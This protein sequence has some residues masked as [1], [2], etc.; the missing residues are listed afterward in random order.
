M[1]EPRHTRSRKDVCEIYLLDDP[2]K[3]KENLKEYI[4]DD[5]H[6]DNEYEL[7]C[8]I[9]NVNG[10]YIKNCSFSNIIADETT[11]KILYQYGGDIEKPEQ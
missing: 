1:V 11:R 9:Y 8:R 6:F 7:I 2:S 10:L 4:L 3:S 5:Y